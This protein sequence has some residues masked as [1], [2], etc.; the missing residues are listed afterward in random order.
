MRTAKL[1]SQNKGPIELKLSVLRD[2]G[3]LTNIQVRKNNSVPYSRNGRLKK[4]N[5][6]KLLK[7]QYIGLMT[8][9]YVLKC[10]NVMRISSKRSV[11]K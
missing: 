4:K 5:P 7:N 3:H 8:A 2:I 11:K 6:V 9:K 1:K 10:P